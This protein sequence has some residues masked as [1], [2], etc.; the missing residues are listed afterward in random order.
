MG[1]REA[2]LRHY[3]KVLRPKF[4]ALRKA[5]ADNWSRPIDIMDACW[6]A[7]HFEGEGTIS[8]NQGGITG[9]Y[10]P[11]V[12]LS[13]TD[14]QT[15]DFFCRYWPMKTRGATRRPTENAKLVWTWRLSG[16]I[17]IHRFISTIEPHLRTNRCKDRFAV[18][19]QFC[20]HMLATEYNRE[21]DKTW[22]IALCAEIRFLNQRGRLPAPKEGMS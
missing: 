2:S 11:V 9:A 10:K 13:S 21:G 4:A 6:A 8:I 7:G 19:K 14:E 20:E 18:V 3:N 16:A 15:I 17:R 5:K 12:S 1:S 22:K